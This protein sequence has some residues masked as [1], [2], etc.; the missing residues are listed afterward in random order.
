MRV[1]RPRNFWSS[2]TIATWPRS[3]TGSSAAIGEV[4]S[5]LS[6]LR[7]MAVAT[8]SLNFSSR[9]NTCIST[10]DSSTMPTMAS[11]SITGSCETSYIFMRW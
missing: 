10:S 5:S 2:I 4:T 9:P 7:T 1:I 11:P 8:G 3:N 6:S